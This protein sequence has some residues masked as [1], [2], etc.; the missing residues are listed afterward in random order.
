MRNGNIDE[1]IG[2]AQEVVTASTPA[3][4]LRRLDG[5]ADPVVQQPVRGRPGGPSAA[6]A[7]HPRTQLAAHL[8]AIERLAF[9]VN[10]GSCSRPGQGYPRTAVSQHLHV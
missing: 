10:L 9:I 3:G 1:T 4:G 7:D 5:I 6:G 2:D 8:V